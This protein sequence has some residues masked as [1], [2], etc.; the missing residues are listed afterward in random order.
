M[1]KNNKRF[2]KLKIIRKKKGDEREERKEIKG[3]LHRTA[4]AE[5]EVYNNSKKCDWKKKKKIKKLN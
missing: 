3:K 1:Y 5:V 4:N 2:K